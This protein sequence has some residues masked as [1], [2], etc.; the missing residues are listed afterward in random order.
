MKITY[1]D[2]TGIR[3]LMTEIDGNEDP[4]E[5]LTDS[6]SEILGKLNFVIAAMEQRRRDEDNG[7]VVRKV[8][9]NGR[10]IA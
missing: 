2:F 6:E 8:W 10:R 1:N 5:R 3:D 9:K 4:E 7:V